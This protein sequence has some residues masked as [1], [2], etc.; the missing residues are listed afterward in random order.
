M[1]YNNLDD[2]QGMCKRNPPMP[3]PVMQQ[4]QNVIGSNDLKIEVPF[5]F[6]FY[7]TVRKEEGGCGEFR[8][9]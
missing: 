9:E 8:A 4:K 5:I 1:Y 7:P 2:K 3:F 6:S